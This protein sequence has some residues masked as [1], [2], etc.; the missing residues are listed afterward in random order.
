MNPTGLVQT[1]YLTV[2]DRPADWRGLLFWSDRAASEGFDAIAAD[3]TNAPE[4]DALF[5]AEDAVGQVRLIYLHLLGREPDEGGLNFWAGK[6]AEP[7][8][9][10]AGIARSLADA[11]QGADGEA[12]A[13]RVDDAVGQTYGD[14]IDVLYAGYYGR[15]SDESGRDF[16]IDQLIASGGDIDPVVSAFGDSAE[17]REAYEGLDS[18]AQVTQLFQNLFGRLPDP[19]GLAFWSGQLDDGAVDLSQ[20][21]LAVAQGASGADVAALAETVRDLNGENAEPELGTLTLEDAL[22]LDELP[23]EYKLEDSA[24]TLLAAL[25]GDDAALLAGA[26]E[27]R[28]TD[29]EIS[30]AD[31]DALTA[32]DNFYAEGLLVDGVAYLT[33]TEQ[34]LRDA[35]VGSQL[36]GHLRQCVLHLRRLHAQPGHVVSDRH[37]APFLYSY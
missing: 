2:Y 9:T 11:A 33:V 16:W 6:L 3:F 19:G 36:H 7:G 31:F 26:S 12:F 21:A 10:V 27:V 1:L 13:A 29:A 32:L 4:F 37:V 25:G 18:E 30:G 5:G 28:V 15:G 14:F 23:P 20:V 35:A 17:F 8:N 34:Q 24:G 22:T